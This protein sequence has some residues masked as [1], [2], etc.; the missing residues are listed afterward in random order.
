[1]FGRLSKRSHSF[2]LK[3]NPRSFGNENSTISILG[4]RFFVCS[5]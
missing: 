1:L 3:L 2:P 4:F 5:I